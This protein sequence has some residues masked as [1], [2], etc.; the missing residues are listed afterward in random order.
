[1]GPQALRVAG[2]L[3]DGTLPY[4]AGPRSLD[5]LIVPCHYRRGGP[6]RAARPPRIA[7]GVPASVNLPTRRAPGAYAFQYLG[8]NARN[9]SYQSRPW[10]GRASATPPT[11]ALVGDEETVAGRGSGGTSTRGATDVRVSPAAF[12]TDEERLRTWPPRRRTRPR[13]REP[14]EHA[15]HLTGESAASSPGC[16]APV[17]AL[18]D[19]HRRRQA[20]RGSLVGHVPPS[21]A[22]TQR[23]DQVIETARAHSR[24]RAMPRVRHDGQPGRRDR[25]LE[26]PGLAPG[27]PRPSSPLTTSVGAV[28][29]ASWSVMSYRDGPGPLENP[30]DGCGPC[31]RAECSAS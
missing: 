8:G 7:A 19:A 21:A 13:R 29:P 14:R 12:A 9:P 1:M 30:G 2:E 16:P 26:Q 27:R 11:L 6:P 20:T 15:A 10:N 23:A 31:P 3:A 5:S 18:G 28:M 25:A 24:L 4:L 17:P 22:P